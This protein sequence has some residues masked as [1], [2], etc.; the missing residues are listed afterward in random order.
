MTNNDV[1]SKLRQRVGGSRLTAVA[2]SASM[3]LL[4]LPGA[5]A[6]SAAPAPGTAAVPGGETGKTAPV[7]AARAAAP[8]TNLSHLNF[9]MDTVPLS[10]VEGHT[11]YQLDRIPSAQAP[12]TYAD[13]KADGSYARIGGGDLDPATGHWSQGAYNADDIARTAVVYLRHWQQTGDPASKERAFQTPAL[14]DVPA[15]HERAE[16]RQRGPLAAGRRHAHAERQAG[17]TAG[18]LRFGRVLL[19]GPHRLGPR[20]RLRRLRRRPT[21][22]SRPSCRSACSWPLARSTSSPS[23][24]T[25]P[26]TRPTASRSRPG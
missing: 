8:L 16:R 26:M 20:R 14:T 4:L 6:A 7:P 11:T 13:K 3:L 2:V 5:G 23:P 1:R 15:D 17:G 10:P 21:R 19:A 22:P 24:S 25:A 9:L 18:P 12:W